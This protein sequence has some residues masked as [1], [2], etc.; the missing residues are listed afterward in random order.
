MKKFPVQSLRSA[1]LAMLF[2]TACFSSV[3]QVI[4]WGWNDY[5][6]TNVPTSATNVLA[7]A[8]GDAHCLVLRTDGTVLAWGLN[9]FG[10]TNVPFDLTNAV[11]VAAG[12]SHS[13][14]LRRDNTIAL[15]GK[16]MPAGVTNVPPGATNIVALALGP[17]AQHALALRTDGTVLDWGGIY[18]SLTA[19]PANARNLVAVAAGDYF[20]VALRSDGRVVAWGTDP[21][22][23]CL[24]VPASATNIVAVATGWNNVAA[25]RADGTALPWGSVSS[26]PANEGFTN[27]VDLA[28]PLS[29]ISGSILAVR[30]DGT[31]TQ[32]GTGPFGPTNNVTT[33]GAGSYDGMALVGSGIPVFPGL[34][35]NRT[36]AG[37]STAYLRQLAVG[38]M[39]ISYQWACNG[40]NLPGATNSVL[41]LTNVQPGQGGTSYT[42]VATNTSGMATSG[43]IALNEVASEVEVQP[44]WQT[45][46]PGDNVTFT[47]TVTGE[48]PF[49]YRW[50]F[51]GTN[52]DGAITNSL[53]LANVHTNQTGTYSLLVSNEFGIVTNTDA[54]LSVVPLPAFESI[55]RTAG[56][57]TLTWSA[58]TGLLFQLQYCS[59]LSSGNWSNLGSTITATNS[60]V[61]GSDMNGTEPQ[62]FYRLLVTP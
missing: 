41:A 35:V 19:P 33:I 46:L 31:V 60:T 4:V 9:G 23:G 54:F 13:L 14:A 57:V 39:P 5:G 26:L 47:A 42:L 17:G 37:G 49:S 62:R 7:L 11:S 6:Q 27:I 22:T 52:L 32:S 51:H 21:G 50:Q 44:Q 34:P 53:S 43:P 56:L 38:G 40:T 55:N 24:N 18:P 2:S 16:I 28:C 12:S 29:G 1:G 25:L 58:T 30:R 59:D 45:A 8:A 48:G 36:V 15:W 20:A 3:G 61:N 10:R